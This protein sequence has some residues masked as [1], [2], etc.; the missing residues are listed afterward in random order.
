[1]AYDEISASEQEETPQGESKSHSAKFL[2]QAV[3]LK[4]GKK[5]SAKKGVNPF[6]KKS[7]KKS[8]KKFS[9]KK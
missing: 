2:K 4:K 7:D 3:A 6:A 9:A 1:M 8:G 5:T